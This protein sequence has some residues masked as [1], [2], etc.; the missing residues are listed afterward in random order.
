MWEIIH[1]ELSGWTWDTGEAYESF[2]PPHELGDFAL[3]E[4]TMRVWLTV[5]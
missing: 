1:T 2:F 3:W 5:G 4:R